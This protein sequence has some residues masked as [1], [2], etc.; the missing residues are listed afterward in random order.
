MKKSGFVVVVEDIMNYV[1]FRIPNI[2]DVLYSTFVNFC[3]C[4]NRDESGVIMERFVE[5]TA[6][7]KSF[8]S[9]DFLNGK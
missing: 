3:C 8:I 5:I 7:N 6:K 4:C 2:V 1:E 9:L